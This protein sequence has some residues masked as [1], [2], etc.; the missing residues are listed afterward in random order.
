MSISRPN[1]PAGPPRNLPLPGMAAI[2]LWML[3]LS[4]IG[5]AGV[6][7]HHYP[8]G[9]IGVSILILSTFFAIGALGLIRSRRWGWSLSL[10][11][12]FLSMCFAF[13]S[14]FRYHEPQWIVMGLV[15]LVFFLYL[16]RTEVV[17]RLR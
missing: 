14:L 5:V 13:Y 8:G 4:M 6:L 1:P 10:G 12:V 7:T 17:G 11:A 16:V 3:A 2:S 15:N 9:A